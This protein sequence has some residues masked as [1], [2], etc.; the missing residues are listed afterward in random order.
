MIP[1]STWTATNKLINCPGPSGP[2]GPQGST[3][4][5]GPS[6]P[7]GSS[8]PAGPQGDS[9]P[10]GPTGAS[11]PT[12]SSGPTGP[13]GDTGLQGITGPQGPTGPAGS[14]GATGPAG[15]TGQAGPSVSGPVATGAVLYWNGTYSVGDTN[16]KYL[17]GNVTLGKA[18]NTGFELETLGKVASA[19]TVSS[20]QQSAV[21]LQNV[22]NPTTIPVTSDTTIGELVFQRNGPF[23][24][25]IKGVQ[26]GYNDALDLRFTTDA[27]GGS[28]TQ[29]DR[30]T[31]K[32]F[33]GRVGIGTSAPECLLDVRGTLR[34]QGSIVNV[35]TATA[36]L[37]SSWT[38][39][40]VDTDMVSLAYTLK[41]SSTVTLVIEGSV[42]YQIIS[43]SG[44]SGETD[45]GLST[46]LVDGSNTELRN[47]SI[48]FESQYLAGRNNI[49]L[50][51][52][53]YVDA[54][55]TSSKTYKLRL[56]NIPSNGA[57]WR[58]AMIVVSEISNS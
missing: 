13:K 47:N 5:L 50:G 36:N 49:I 16:F 55:S 35:Q 34:G 28:N 48:R 31:I 8:G 20:F 32:A 44:G 4:P 57:R 7:T 23:Y 29:T 9:G 41:Q 30:M 42:E 40:G 2:T 12:G 43:S 6:G 37:T 10:A 3:G 33:T 45:G 1:A 39:A 58:R 52:L 26:T 51:D 46:Y 11:G 15:P 53:M 21:F 27:S 38:S 18:T 24:A 14:Q 54:V 17:S 56:T 19:S 25:S 22:N